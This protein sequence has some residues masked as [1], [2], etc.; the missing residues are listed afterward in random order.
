MSYAGIDYGLGKANIDVE[1]GIRYGCISQGS[2]MSE[3]IDDGEYDYGTPTCPR[4]GK[5]AD[6]PH[7]FGE[8]FANGRPE[9]Y[10]REP[11]QCEDYVCVDCKHFFGSES[12]FP[13]EPAGWYY[14]KEGYKLESCLNSD[15]LVT[16]SPYYTHAQFC[17]PCVPGAGNL[18]HPCTDG[19][20]TYCL[21][22]DWFDDG[23]APYTVFSVATDEE[24]KA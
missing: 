18:D 3:A 6:E 17:S 9:D 14:N 16:L 24:V 1:T 12:A 4:C 21:G 11:H 19:P 15:I 22:H 5:D 13:D 2:V 20:R 10:T 7:A 8:T 23:K